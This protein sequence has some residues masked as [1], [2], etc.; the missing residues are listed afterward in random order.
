M[1][2]YMITI[3]TD[4]S[5]L[6]QSQIRASG[7][8]WIDDHPDGPRWDAAGSVHP[9]ATIQ[10]VELRALYEAL[11]SHREDA[12]ITIL[13]DSEYALN[14]ATRWRRGWERMNG[15]TRKG[16]PVRYYDNIRKIW[17]LLDER[18]DNGFETNLEWVPAHSGHPLNEQA[19][20]RAHTA[21]RRA[22][23][24]RRPLRREELN[25]ADP[26]RKTSFA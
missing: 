11:A 17:A 14:C 15:Q 22:K 4:G 1:Y 20:L 24:K 6:R 7:W 25:I 9:Q 2:G 23:Q 19:D 16:K 3:A 12:A 26:V 13:S 10:S 5:W 21:A 18:K 8:A